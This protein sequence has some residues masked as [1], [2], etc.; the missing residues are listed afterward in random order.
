MNSLL[1]SVA[2]RKTAKRAT[3]AVAVC[4]ATFFVAQAISSPQQ[5][6]QDALDY[7]VAGF[8]TGEPVQYA[9]S[10]TPSI[11]AGAALCIF[12]RMMAIFFGWR[13]PVAPRRE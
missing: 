6:A 12:L 3:V 2:A 11:L 13:A 10:G 9:T 4:G 5:T 7:S 8:Q 1:S